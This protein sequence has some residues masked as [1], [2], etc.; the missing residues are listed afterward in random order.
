MSGVRIAESAD[1]AGAADVFAVAPF[2]ATDIAIHVTGALL[3]LAGLVPALVWLGAHLSLLREGWPWALAALAVG[4]YV[5]DF[6]TGFL[7]WAFDT[8]FSD[9]W[10]SIRRMVL[11][12]RE[13]H[14]HP[15][16]IF[17]YGFWHDGG[18]LSWFAFLVS[19]PVFAWVLLRAAAPQPLHAALVLGAAAASLEIVFMLE[20]HKC[21]H[22][23]R[24]PALVRGLQRAHLLLSPTHHLRHHSGRHDRNYCL[25]TGA[26]DRTAG[27]LGAWRL[28]ERVVSRLTGW[29]PREDDRVWL[30]RYGRWPGRTA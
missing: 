29:V 11:L 2:S 30:E 3:N 7:H 24:R 20:F 14:I 8:W 23:L 22:R 27:R 9:D 26:F 16:R 12:V 28:L 5:A 21:G 18:M 19:T 4:T 25:I 13:H 1:H 15:E 10:P 6:V 17:R